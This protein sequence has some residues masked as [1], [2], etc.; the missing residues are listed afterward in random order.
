MLL[1]P[2]SQMRSFSLVLLRRLLFRSSSPQRISL[3]DHLSSQSLGTL[4]R[5]LLHSLL[6]EP[7]PVVR[8]RAVDAICDLA[9]N[10]M[11][12]G[13]PWHALQAQSFSMAESADPSARESAFRVFSGSP[14]LVMDLQIESVLAVLQKGLQDQ[15]SI[16]VRIIRI[17]RNFDIHESWIQVRLAALRASVAYFS[18]SDVSQ[19]A[20][21]LSLLY[22][23]LNTLPSLPHGQLPAFLSTLTPLASSHPNLFAPHL[24][25]LLSFLPGLILPAVDA[26]PTPTVAR[27]NPGSGGSVFS[28]PPPGQAGNG[29]GKAAATPEDEINEEE[30]EMRKAALEFMI[31]LS[32]ARPSMVKRVDGWTAAVVRGCLEGMA[33]I[34]EEET[35]MWLQS[36]VR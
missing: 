36:D 32:E 11:A 33:E 7:S 12:R 19:Q 2:R 30:D 10:S 22:P 1:T 35:D 16:E 6:H 14:N 13:R 9:N 8:R 17:H 18:A 15:Q 3:Y 26:G 23:M 20:Q 27:P 34:P 5:I 29:K 21:A 28:F 4:E 25:A 24:P 31:S